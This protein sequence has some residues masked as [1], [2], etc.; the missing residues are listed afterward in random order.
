[1]SDRVDIYRERV[2]SIGTIKRNYFRC[3]ANHVP[4]NINLVHGGYN[5]L[6]DSRPN[7]QGTVIDGR[8]ITSARVVR[9]GE[10]V[11]YRPNCADSQVSKNFLTI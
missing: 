1:M 6:T 10:V 9:N 5:I 2:Y 8:L 4:G 3:N 11:G 7:N